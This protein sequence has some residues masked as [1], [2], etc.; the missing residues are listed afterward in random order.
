MEQPKFKR[1][2]KLLDDVLSIKSH[3]LTPQ[4]HAFLRH[5]RDKG[6]WAISE[7]EQAQLASVLKAKGHLK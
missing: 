2:A 4:E 7:E 5:V 1:L 6:V 3:E